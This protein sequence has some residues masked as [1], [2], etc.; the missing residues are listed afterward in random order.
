MRLKLAEI[1]PETRASES[2]SESERQCHT[3][4]QRDRWSR[5]LDGGSKPDVKE[6][7]GTSHPYGLCLCISLGLGEAYPDS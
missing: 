2:E 3:H 5:T 4:A 1:E 7:D 6:T